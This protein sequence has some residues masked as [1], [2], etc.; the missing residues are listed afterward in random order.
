MLSP[1]HGDRYRAAADPWLVDYVEHDDLHTLDYDAA[2]D[3]YETFEKVASDADR[4]Y[5]GAVDRFYLLTAILA[6]KDMQHPWLYDRCREVELAPDFHIDLWA[7]E[8]GKS[9][10]ITFAGSVQEII[11]DPEITIGIFGHTKDISEK[12]VAQIK[13]EF[14]ANNDLRSLYADVCWLKPAS[15]APVWSN[16]AFTVRRK[17]NPKEATVE[18]HG[19][20]KGQPT[21]RHFL[22][23]IYDDIV[24]LESVST[25]EQVAKT[26]TAFEMSDNLGAGEGRLQ[27]IGTRYTFADTYGS[28][29]D[30]DIVTPRIYAATLNGKIDGKPV[31]MTPAIWATKRKT[32]RSTL[33]AQMLQNPLSGKERMFYPQWFTPWFTRPA[34]MNVYITCDPSRGRSASSDRTAIVV[35]GIDSNANK[36]LLDGACHRMKLSQRW[37]HLKHFHQKWSKV[38]GINMVRAGYERYGQQADDEYFTERMREEKYVFSIAELAWPREGGGSKVDRV[39][40]LQPDVEYGAYFLPGIVHVQGIGPSLWEADMDEAKM[41]FKELKGDLKAIAELKERGQEYLC[42]KPITRK[43]E[44]GEIYDLTRLLMEQMLFFP[45]ATFD[46]LIDSASRIY[47]MEALPASIH[48]EMPKLPAEADV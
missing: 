35:T 43:N 7:R 25:P 44:E 38:P 41:S 29:L 31:L 16:E 47:D 36:Y 8:H 12:F 37:D 10:I 34:S 23:R 17:G 5:L 20:V 27:I 32:Q 40:R 14:E 2:C 42:A 13:R 4:S 1:Y 22:L 6:R 48:D 3:F 18:A 24:T 19:L 26:T 21:S 45:F 30:R 28:I 39:G 46:D 33:A 9:T 15:E 11:R